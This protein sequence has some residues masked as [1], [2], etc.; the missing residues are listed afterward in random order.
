MWPHGEE[1]IH[2]A[3][4]ETYIPLLNALN[5]LKAEGVE[6]KLTIGLTPI[7]VYFRSNSYLMI[8]FSWRRWEPAPWVPLFSPG[9]HP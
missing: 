6:P 3:L 2:E 9:T 1:M 4:A 8:I 5:D 7:L